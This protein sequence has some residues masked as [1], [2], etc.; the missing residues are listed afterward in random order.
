MIFNKIIYTFKGSTM[1]LKKTLLLIS[2]FSLFTVL[3]GKSFASMDPKEVSQ[4]ADE[5]KEIEIKKGNLAID[6]SF[7]QG[8][9]N[10]TLYKDIKAYVGKEIKKNEIK[11]IKKSLP[12][13]KS[14]DVN[15]DNSLGNGKKILLDKGLFKIYDDSSSSVKTLD[16]KK[17]NINSLT[18][19]KSASVDNLKNSEDKK[20]D[21]KVAYNNQTKKFGVITGNAIVKLDPA[22][23]INLPDSS[24]KVIKSYKHL[25]LYV[26]K[27]PQNIQY[28]DAVV[29]LKDANP[30]NEKVSDEQRSLVN[31]E[32][33]ENFKSA[34]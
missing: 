2:T 11:S 19:N 23:D 29:K 22:K 20:Y 16:T 12:T 4:E 18:M 8:G 25:G 31:V 26:V 30:E 24:F 33:L 28:K 5:K 7:T 17:S 21:Y 3:S 14:D 15:K 1:R 27:V 13:G 6:Q 10:Y 9:M 34:M 32:I